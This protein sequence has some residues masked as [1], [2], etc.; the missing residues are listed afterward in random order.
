MR[1]MIFLLLLLSAVCFLQAEEF[2][3]LPVQAGLSPL[4]GNDLPES[5]PL[6]SIG[7]RLRVAF[8]W[9]KSVLGFA[10]SEV[11]SFDRIE[12]H[13]TRLHQDWP[14]VDAGVEKIEIYASDDNIHFRPIR[15]FQF[16][17]RRYR[18]N[19]V[20]T[21]RI[22]LDGRFRG[23]YIKLYAPREKAYYVYG[24]ED[25]NGG[26]VQALVRKRL[27]VDSFAVPLHA[28]EQLKVT[29][30]TRK[31]STDNGNQ[32]AIVLKPENRLL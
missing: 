25:L 3:R 27:L 9:Q 8:P 26:G 29:L 31:T 11:T 2:I 1:T 10:F 19:E 5:V 20:E 28:G 4:N 22:T 7:D 24:L 14:D 17:H 16:S 15:D 23:K 30:N 12:L 18:E 6:K 13:L 32:V 21:D